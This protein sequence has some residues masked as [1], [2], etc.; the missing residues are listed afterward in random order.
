MRTAPAVSLL[1]PVLH[2]KSI[3]LLVLKAISVGEV[4]NVW[5]LK[6]FYSLDL[7]FNEAISVLL[8]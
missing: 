1:N 6:C 8:Y 2:V 5:C 3:I 7:I 4:R